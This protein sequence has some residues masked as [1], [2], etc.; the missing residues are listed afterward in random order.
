M[1]SGDA[2]VTAQLE[3]ALSG[4]GHLDGALQGI[5]FVTGAITVGRCTDAEAYTGSYEVTPTQSEQILPTQDKIMTSDVRV[6]P[7][8]SNYGLI[9]WNGTVLTVS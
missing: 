3:A 8:P 2:S 7:I 5:G 9:T 1:L 4:T 6:L